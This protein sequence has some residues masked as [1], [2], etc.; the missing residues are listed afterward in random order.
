MQQQKELKP[1]R[2]LSK[3]KF[4]NIPSKLNNNAANEEA[5]NDKSVGRPQK[6]GKKDKKLHRNNIVKS[7]KFRESHNIIQ[8]NRN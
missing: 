7:P 4:S 6:G 5:N 8:N 3:R 1:K 2:F